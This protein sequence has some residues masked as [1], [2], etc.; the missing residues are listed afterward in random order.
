[1]G[2]TW[3]FLI[4]GRELGAP[5]SSTTL[6]PSGKGLILDAQHRSKLSSTASASFKLIEDRFPPDSIRPHPPQR[7]PFQGGSFVRT[8]AYVFPTYGTAVHESSIYRDSGEGRP[9]S[10]C[11]PTAAAGK[12]CCIPIIVNSTIARWLVS[13]RKYFS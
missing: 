5:L 7:G 11:A 10:R 3:H 8:S 13:A 6:N 2:Y 4:A 9:S 1:M 12:A